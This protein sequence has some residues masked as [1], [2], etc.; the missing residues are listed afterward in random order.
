MY[1]VDT[2]LPVRLDR[3]L[4]RLFPVLTQGV[5]E[6]SLR[7][8]NIKVNDLK[9]AANFRVNQGDIITFAPQ[10]SLLIAKTTNSIAEH[11]SFSNATIILAEKIIGEYLIYDH[12]HFIAINKPAKLATQGGSKI[13]LSLNDG[14]NYL[15]NRHNLQLKLVHRLDCETS[16]VML[17]AKTY[18]GATKIGTAL[19]HKIIEKKYLAIVQGVPIKNHG[20]ISTILHK[21]KY[22]V[23]SSDIQK[24]QVEG[25][26]AITS[27]NVIKNL[28]YHTF[29]E[30]VPHTGRMHQL[31]VH[32]KVLGHPIVGDEK[33]GGS[34]TGKSKYM[35][36]HSARTTIPL[37]VFGQE[38]I[39]EVSLPQYFMIYLNEPLEPVS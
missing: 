37:G 4:K 23:I 2:I 31:R 36:L 1:I 15:N 26:V 18:Y 14:I 8:K 39:L 24:N 30:F 27:Y 21:S 12:E 32:A 7:I 17:I 20:Q 6:Q 25:K 35:L 34:T 9:C 3:Y 16:G 11:K 28:Q 19:E 33:Y 13:T 38:I 29:V 10:I 22:G 5:I